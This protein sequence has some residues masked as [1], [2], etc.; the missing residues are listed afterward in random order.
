[1][2]PMCKVWKCRFNHTHNTSIH[3]CGICN[4]FGH[5]Q[6]E[7]G[8]QYYIDKLKNDIDY[9]KQL[10]ISIWCSMNGCI[11]KQTHTI[12]AHHCQYCKINHSDLLCPNNPNNKQLMKTISCPLCRT[13][14]N[15]YN[16]TNLTLF[17]VDTKCSICLTNECNIILPIC[18][19][20]CMCNMCF[21]IL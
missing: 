5:G 6:I 9:N 16:N 13:N 20:V 19:H 1:M 8:K 12:N 3:L 11:N 18:R 7:C 14:N 4:E 10:D 21:N 15:I 17:G 2:E